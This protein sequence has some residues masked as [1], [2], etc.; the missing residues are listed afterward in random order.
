MN[1]FNRTVLAF[2]STLWILACLGLIALAWNTDQMLDLKAGDLNI[3]AFIDSTD[4]VRIAFTAMMLALALIGVVTFI[5]AVVPPGPG[6]SGKTIPVRGENGAITNVPITSIE[7]LLKRELQS[8]PEIRRATVRI[9]E[10][11]GVVS[12]DLDLAVAPG[13]NVTD[14]DALANEITGTIL[15]DRV[16][17]TNAERPRVRAMFD[18]AGSAS[19]P[20]AAAPFASTYTPEPSEPLPRIQ[21]DTAETR[22][23]ARPRPTWR[24]EVLLGEQ[25]PPE[26]RAEPDPS[27]IIDATYTELPPVDEPPAPGAIFAEK[28][29]R[30]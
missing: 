19:R 28:E 7:T 8:Y 3:Q 16:G 23:Y 13:S 15:R 9:R 30:A 25:D 29:P 5:T 27:P 4:D 18:T 14:V 17:L 10:N 11:R 1:G 22:T 2:Y 21:W 12:T 6:S 20:T 24:G 26:P